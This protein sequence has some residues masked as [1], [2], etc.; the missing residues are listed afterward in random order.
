MTCLGIW[1][2]TYKQPRK[3]CT[4]CFLTGEILGMM[5]LEFCKTNSNNMEVGLETGSD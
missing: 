5:R 4:V 2:L 1:T 3:Y